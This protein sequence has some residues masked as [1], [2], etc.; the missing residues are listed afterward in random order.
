MIQYKIGDATRPEIVIGPGHYV[1]VH[2]CNDIDKWGAGFVNALTR[3]F[4]MYPK[5]SYHDWCAQKPPGSL[6]CSGDPIRIPTMTG[7]AILGEVQFVPLT[8]MVN[9]DKYRTCKDELSNSSL[10]VTSMIA[11]HEIRRGPGG[12]APIRYDA[13][14]R[15]LGHVQDWIKKQSVC[16]RVIMPRI[17]CGLAGG[18][19]DKVQ[20]LIEKQL[21]SVGI[22]V[23]VCDLIP[24]GLKAGT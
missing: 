14:E 5:Q 3:R 21:S 4:G 2:V 16:T 24:S 1:I 6:P 15:C 9:K 10:Y 13:L 19:W 8:Y 12:L 22:D 23:T 17:G 7:S 11:Q 20:P 18:T